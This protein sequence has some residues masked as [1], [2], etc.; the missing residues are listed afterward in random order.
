MRFAFKTFGCRLNQ[1]EAALWQA[2]LESIGW[3]ATPFEEAQWIIVHSCAVTAKAERDS[4]R[5][6]RHLRQSYPHAQLAL[7]GCAAELVQEG[8]DLIVRKDNKANL[9]QILSGQTI[10]EQLTV[11]LHTT[12]ASIAIQD[13]CDRF[14]SYCI[15]PYLRGKPRSTPFD[16]IIE[17]AKQLIALD[18][19]EIVITGCHI[20]LYQDGDKTIVHL[21]DAL[22]ALPGDV[23]FRLGSVEPC[24]TDEMRFI[25]LMARHPGKIC[26]FLHIP[27][28]SASDAILSRMNRPY[29]AAHIRHVL[30]YAL[31]KIPDL[32]LGCDLIVGFPGETDADAAATEALLL[33]YPFSAAHVFPYSPRP[34]TPAA[35][36]PDQIPASVVTARAKRLR[37][38][39]ATQREA[40]AKSLLHKPQTVLLERDHTGWNEQHI[41]C[42]LPHGTRGELY[43][44]TPIQYHDGILLATPENPL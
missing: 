22:C 10:P 27:I 20:A 18:Y 31:A 42:Y 2:Q 23:R 38:I 11:K 26:R 14:C 39:A 37:T 16:M 13:G 5:E 33:D 4:V 30:D 35:D 43:C 3:M 34:G 8:A 6:L 19:H 1:A 32:A 7:V 36:F 41:S 29:S 15:V 9:P 40:F 28:Q 17:R 25:D 21:L 12:R 24:T 44:F